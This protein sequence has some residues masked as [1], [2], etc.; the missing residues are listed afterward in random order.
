M[1]GK[2][3][4]SSTEQVRRLDAVSAEGDPTSKH[5]QNITERNSV[6]RKLCNECPLISRRSIGGQPA[7]RVLR[8]AEHASPLI[9][10]L[11]GPASACAAPT[12]PCHVLKNQMSPDWIRASYCEMSPAPTTS[13][14]T[15]R[16][17]YGVVLP[18]APALTRLPVG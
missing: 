8:S 6:A 11:N 3:V 7:A 4:T 16:V 12:T 1:L 18:R 5:L 17:V 9:Q 13:G 2:R 10:R 15:K 14:L